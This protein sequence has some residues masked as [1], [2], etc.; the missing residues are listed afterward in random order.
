MANLKTNHEISGGAS[1]KQAAKEKQSPKGRCASKKGKV[2]AL[3]MRA[4]G[5]TLVEM[6]KATDW[7]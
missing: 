2:I 7:Q 4:K 3:L 5:A 6:G 1:T